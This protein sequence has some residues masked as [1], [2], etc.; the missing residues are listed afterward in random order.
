MGALGQKK[1]CDQKSNISGENNGKVASKTQTAKVEFSLNDI[2]FGMKKG[3]G[4]EIFSNSSRSPTWLNQND[5]EKLGREF[6]EK[7]DF[8]PGSDLEKLLR[9]EFGCDII[10]GQ[11]PFASSVL[12]IFKPDEWSITISAGVAGAYRRAD[13]AQ[14][15]SHYI[16]H[17]DG[18]SPLNLTYDS[19]SPQN[20]VD[21]RLFQESLWFS[22]SILMP[23][24]DFIK[25]CGQK[26][27]VSTVSGIFH[28]PQE[29]VILRAEQ[30]GVPHKLEI[31]YSPLERGFISGGVER[32]FD[33]K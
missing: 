28:T 2:G 14:A 12:S 6:V 8:E 22:F 18:E 21:V 29:W 19:F 16:L 13:L 7:Y 30:L 32:G 17:Y 27:M 4:S 1:S 9:D 24:A 25:V 26:L 3:F 10:Q 5:I 31:G 20:N 33:L 15:L 11:D 23:A